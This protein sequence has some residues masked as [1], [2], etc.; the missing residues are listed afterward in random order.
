MTEEQFLQKLSKT[1]KHFN[2]KW[3]VDD[4]M[5]IRL[6]Q[7]QTG[8]IYC[9]VTAVCQMEENVYVPSYQPTQAINKLGMARD[10]GRK[11]V[12]AAD[13]TFFTPFRKKLLSTVGLGERNCPDS[14]VDD[15]YDYGLDGDE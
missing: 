4:C 12:D 1:A 14:E 15:L 6:N 5:G 2:S 13:D 10:L 9:P 8:L 3:V 11:V 7:A